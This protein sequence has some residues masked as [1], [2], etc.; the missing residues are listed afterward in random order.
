MGWT[1][2]FAHVS[3]CSLRGQRHLPELDTLV[4]TVK[5]QRIAS[6]EHMPTA[7]AWRSASCS[8]REPRWAWTARV[9][10]SRGG[11]GE[12]D[13]SYRRLRAHPQDTLAEAYSIEIRQF[14]FV[15]LVALP[16]DPPEGGL[17]DAAGHD[18][19]RFSDPGAGRDRRRAPVPVFDLALNHL[20][21]DKICENLE[22][23][24]MSLLDAVDRFGR[25]RTRVRRPRP[26]STMRQNRPTTWVMFT[27]RA[28]A[29][30][31]AVP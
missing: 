24:L 4:G 3:R 12:V 19:G 8:A 15:F 1:A 16:R 21:L 26:W 25:S 30:G 22:Q 5:A 7:V 11:T 28:R 6:V 14:I 17:A 18:A 2:A 9:R 27:K 13:R 20:P 23:N 29:D 31:Q 10:P